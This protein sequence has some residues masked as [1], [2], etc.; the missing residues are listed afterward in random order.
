M[1]RNKQ[2]WGNIWREKKTTTF[3]ETYE[4]KKEKKSSVWS[5]P[6]Y[7]TEEATIYTKHKILKSKKKATCEATS[8]DETYDMKKATSS[9]ETYNVKKATSFEETYEVK[10]GKKK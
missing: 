8:F 10:K 9:E 3:D 6:L 1:K 7:S 4:A 2:F 5:S